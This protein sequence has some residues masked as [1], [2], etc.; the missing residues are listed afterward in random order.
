REFDFLTTL[1]SDIGD[2]T[3]ETGGDEDLH[4]EWIC[5]GTLPADRPET[6]GSQISWIAIGI[7]QE[8]VSCYYAVNAPRADL[9]A[10]QLLIRGKVSAEAAREKLADEMQSLPNIAHSLLKA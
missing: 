2:L 3:V 8:R 7:A 1:W 10:L 6:P 4:D 5:R 9:S